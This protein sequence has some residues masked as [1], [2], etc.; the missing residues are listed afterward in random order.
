MLDG[1]PG[2]LPDMEYEL[3]ADFTDLV[4]TD[5]IYRIIPFLDPIGEIWDGSTVDYGDGTGAQPLIVDPSGAFTLSHTYQDS[6][7]FSV[8]V[9]I[10][11][12]YGQSLERTVLA[13]VANA[14]PTGVLEVSAIDASVGLYTASI[15]EALD[16]SPADMLAGLRFSFALSAGQLVGDYAAA[17]ESSTAQFTLAGGQDYV[18]Y[19]RVIDKDGGYSD[20]Q[21]TIELSGGQPPT[22]V[23]AAPETAV[24]GA[25]ITVDGSS[26]SG[27]DQSSSSSLIYVWD[28]DGD[29]IFGEVGE[30]ALFG[31]EVGITPTIS[32]AGVDGPSVLRIGLRVTDE[33]G[34]TDETTAEILIENA[35]PTLDYVAVADW[36]T[37]IQLSFSFSDVGL[38][39]THYVTIDWGDGRQH[40][41]SYASGSHVVNHDYIDGGVYTVGITVA[42]DDGGSAKETIKAF[43]TG[44]RVQDGVLE[45]VGTPGN[46]QFV[47]MISGNQILAYN[48]ID[49]P[50]RLTYRSFSRAAISNIE[51]YGGA[52]NDVLR[53]AGSVTENILLSGG[54]GNDYLVGGLGDDILIG[55]DGNDTLIGG[56]G[57]N[58]LIGG[59]GRDALHGHA[60]ED[61]LIAGYTSFDDRS[62]ALAAILNEWKSGRSYEDRIANLRG[63]SSQGDSFQS[64]LNQDYYLRADSTEATV[65]DDNISDRISGGAGRDWYFANIDQDDEGILD[66]IIGL[67]ASEIYDDLDWIE[68]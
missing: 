59:K 64:R 68:I 21:K 40:S 27:P 26:S 52:G 10:V 41:Q 42:D 55:G 30:Q 38:L 37:N 3:G 63:V 22:A 60:G 45:V 49:T 36:A 11:N 43:V 20:Y 65:F 12:E 1:G 46:D 54:A 58:L 34:L 16:I 33:D 19:G 14:N 28:L 44:M 25:S 50:G 29:G 24:E 53:A 17:S 8:T 23:I 51:A 47:F 67:N 39:D 6:G 5:S 32:L 57:N 9:N 4:E 2:D 31:D 13:P 48:T 61:L 62:W 7:P 66:Q 15:R 56:P 18:V 35:A